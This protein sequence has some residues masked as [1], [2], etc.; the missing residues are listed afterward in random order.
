MANKLDL[1]ALTL[2]CV[3]RAQQPNGTKV[4]IRLLVGLRLSKRCIRREQDENISSLRSSR[5]I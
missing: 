3:R 5:H 4:V 1:T 2:A